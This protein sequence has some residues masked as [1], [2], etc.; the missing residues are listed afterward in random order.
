MN[1]QTR[2]A[3]YREDGA[4]FKVEILEDTSDAEW[5]RYKLKILTVLEQS[6]L[7]ATPFTEG[8]VFD[9]SALRAAGAYGGMWHLEES[10]NV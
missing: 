6:P 3:L 2:I 4:V 9:V 8:E 10:A 5:R 7:Y 1:E